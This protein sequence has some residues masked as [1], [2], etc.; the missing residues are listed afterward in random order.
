MLRGKVSLLEVTVIICV[1]STAVKS[2]VLWYISV[3]IPSSTTVSLSSRNKLFIIPCA[4]SYQS[5]VIEYRTVHLLD[6][7]HDITGLKFIIYYR[8]YIINLFIFSSMDFFHMFSFT[9]RIAALYY[10][11]M[12]R[13]AFCV[14]TLAFKSRVFFSCLLYRCDRFFHFCNRNISGYLSPFMYIL[15][16]YSWDYLMTSFDYRARKFCRR[17]FRIYREIRCF[18][19]SISINSS[20]SLSQSAFRRLFDGFFNFAYRWSVLVTRSNSMM[21]W[22]LPISFGTFFYLSLCL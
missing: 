15:C 19:S 7:V 13:K 12:F 17:F 5:I 20:H 9:V 1:R 4:V 16:M 18:R 14:H 8:W 21:L 22:S 2:K 10:C 6:D 11:R 3:L